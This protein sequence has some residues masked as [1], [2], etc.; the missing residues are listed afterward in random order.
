MDVAVFIWVLRM[1]HA[2][3]ASVLSRCCIC[4]TLMLQVFHPDVAYIFNTCF[5]HVLD[6]CCKCFNYFRRTLQMFSLD[7]AKVYQMLHLLQLLSLS[8]RG[9]G[10][11]VTDRCGKPCGRRSRRSGRG[12]QSCAGHGANMW[13]GLTR[14]PMWSRRVART[15]APFPVY[16]DRLGVS[17]PVVSVYDYGVAMLIPFLIR[18]G[19]SYRRDMLTHIGGPT[20]SACPSGR[21]PSYPQFHGPALSPRVLPARGW[22][23]PQR[24]RTH[25]VLAWPLGGLVGMRINVWVLGCSS[26]WLGHTNMGQVS[27]WAQLWAFPFCAGFV[28]SSNILFYSLF[29][30][31]VKVNSQRFCGSATAA[32]AILRRYSVLGATAKYGRR[33]LV[34][35]WME[36]ESASSGVGGPPLSSL[37]HPSSRICAWT[38]RRNIVLDWIRFKLTLD[39]LCSWFR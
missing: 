3:V 14:D 38:I 39:H 7:V 12:T 21:N 17:C 19:W 25:R 29:F 28:L 2:Y 5:P 8:T 10:G 35:A 6:V 1:F 37:D 33:S 26:V 11:G 27:S 30:P 32:A 22:R 9:Y 13:H 24:R 16:I 20:Y 34:I 36:L 31:H 23:R 15:S 4:F 18:F